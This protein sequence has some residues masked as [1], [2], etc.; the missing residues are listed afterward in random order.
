MTGNGLAPETTGNGA[1]PQSFAASASR[2]FGGWLTDNGVG[3]ACTTYQANRLFLI[4]ADH[5][6][7]WS[8]NWR[9]L[10][11]C[12][13]MATESDSLYV[14]SLYQLWRFEN[15]LRPGETRGK[16]DRLFVP[17]TGYVTGDIDIHD[18]GFGQGGRPIF[19]NAAYSC[20]AT[21]SSTHSFVPLWQPP[22]ISKLAAEDR[23]HL[24]GL[25]MRDGRPAFVTMVAE[26][27][28]VEG[29]REHRRDGGAVIDVA[30]NE[31]VLR[32]L[33]MPHSPRWYR[34]RLWLHNSG[35]GEFGY[36]DLAAGKFEPVCF[37]PG[38]LRGL[39]FVGDFALVG[40]SRSRRS[41]EVL[42]GLALGEQ[43]EAK[44]V[45]AR[46]GLAIINLRTGDAE[47]RF[48][49][50]GTVQELYDVAV[51]EGCRSPAAIGFE[52]DEISREISFRPAPAE[53]ISE[54][55]PAAEAERGQELS[56]TIVHPMG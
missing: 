22:F 29:W 19:V 32:G 36:V 37:L 7:R 28:V 34:D 18:I 11:R 44:N 48:R 38:Y 53:L 47:Q 4:G 21:V 33:S 56:S 55:L 52:T 24:N 5:D 14:G 43:L 46:C 12:M 45:E 51:I 31:V 10:K 50:S 3:L 6:G 41:Q 35:T 30:T 1:K 26:T 25:A 54:V 20:L 23:C 8:M 16:H 13:G 40:M 9:S 2:H 39:A 27:D 15:V 17:R 42:N 49:F